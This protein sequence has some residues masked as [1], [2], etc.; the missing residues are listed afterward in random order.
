M[1][2]F[3]IKKCIDILLKESEKTPLN[4][5]DLWNKM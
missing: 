5:I 2:T 4:D 3:P 1:K